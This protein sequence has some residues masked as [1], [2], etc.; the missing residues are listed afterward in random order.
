MQRPDSRAVFMSEKVSNRGVYLLWVD[1]TWP[2][3]VN[4]L[5][6]FYLRCPIAS[7]HIP[8]LLYHWWKHWKLLVY[9]PKQIGTWEHIR[10]MSWVRNLLPFLEPG[11]DSFFLAQGKFSRW[12]FLKYDEILMQLFSTSYNRGSILKKSFM[13]KERAWQAHP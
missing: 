7:L 13:A 9:N 8:A 4:K 1:Q 5:T 11:K 2:S 6:I 3:K 12:V 10:S